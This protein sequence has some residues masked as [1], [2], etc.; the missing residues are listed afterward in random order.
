MVMLVEVFGI[1]SRTTVSAI[2]HENCDP[3]N[4]L[5]N[6]AKNYSIMNRVDMTETIRRLNESPSA[7]L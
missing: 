2:G 5:Y 4:N 3:Y 1:D 7:K 6:W